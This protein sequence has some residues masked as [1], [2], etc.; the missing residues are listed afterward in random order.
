MI[1]LNQFYSGT[2]NCPICNEFI[3]YKTFVIVSP[4]I[5]ERIRTNKKTSRLGI[6]KSCY[7]ATFN[8]R[9]DDKQMKQIYE[10]YRDADYNNLRFKW[11]KWYG[12]EYQQG[13]LSEEYIGGRK[14]ELSDFLAIHLQDDVCKV[15]DIG[16][17]NGELIPDAIPGNL[18]TIQ[19]YV[20]D[21]S[22][23]DTVAQVT[24]IDSLNEIDEF[25]LAIYSHTIEHV[26][27]PASELE[28]ILQHT[29]HIYIETPYG[30]PKISF[31]NKS[32]VL[33]TFFVLLSLSP[34]IWRNMF[35]LSVG[36]KSKV[37]ILKQSEHINFFEVETIEKLA[38]IVNCDSKVRL[39][40]VNN[41]LGEKHQVIQALFSKRQ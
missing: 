4:W 14:K 24:K 13:H 7:G 17:G 10:C 11:E 2:G 38:N 25:D 28:K 33:N 36:F 40:L 26:A 3:Q 6:C 39:K 34:T 27:D 23:A 18:G 21:I 35:S 41:P 32:L 31:L 22:N 8:F 12:N 1:W 9:Y 5:R 19:K 29:N 30:V 20:L 15:V 16:G 37:R